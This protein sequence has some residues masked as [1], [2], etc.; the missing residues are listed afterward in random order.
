MEIGLHPSKTR[1]GNIGA[2]QD[3][4]DEDAEEGSY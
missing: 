3:I 2:I 1:T 4:E